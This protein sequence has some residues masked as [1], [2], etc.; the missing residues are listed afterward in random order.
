[1]DGPWQPRAWGVG[2]WGVGACQHLG[3]CLY[4]CVSVRVFVYPCV[5]VTLTPF[6]R[7]LMEGKTETLAL[8]HFTTDGQEPLQL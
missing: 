7:T 8:M 1:M 5:F 3:K 2:G 6:C 4:V